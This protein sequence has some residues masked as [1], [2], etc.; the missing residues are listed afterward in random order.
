LGSFPLK[1]SLT[2]YLTLGILVDP[3]TNTIS[4]IS[5]FFNWE[6][7]KATY[8]GPKVFLK[9]SEFNS[10]NLALVK[11]S[12]KSTPSTK[13]SI[14]SLTSVV[15]DK[16]LLAFSTS[17]FNFWTA[18]LSLDTSTSFFFLIYFMK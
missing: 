7:S 6:S 18:L 2:N 9:R 3:P 17:F 15:E 16:A 14:S 13:S 12:S 10:S 4:L 11:T 1:K 8:T 5:P